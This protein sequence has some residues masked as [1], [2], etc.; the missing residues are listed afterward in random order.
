MKPA[1]Q[2]L[3]FSII[4]LWGCKR[5][6]ITVDD[7]VADCPITWINA[8][9]E[10]PYCGNFPI[11]TISRT[12]KCQS[13]VG[14]L[15]MRGYYRGPNYSY[16]IQG[17]LGEKLS[18]NRYYPLT[19]DFK[20]GLDVKPIE[21]DTGTE[22][23]LFL[24]RMTDTL[25]FGP[26]FGYDNPFEI[27]VGKTTSGYFFKVRCDDFEEIV[28]DGVSDFSTAHLEI[29]RI[30]SALTFR[31][32]AALPN[33]KVIS[34]NHEKTIDFSS[35]AFTVAIGCRTVPEYIFDCKTRYC[36]WGLLDFQYSGQA[37]IIPDAFDCNSVLFQ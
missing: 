10:P 19:T 29:Q 32:N 11:D 4:T 1:I 18:F 8:Y 23:N 20:V 36:S 15:T 6:N 28:S 7:H 24:G 34:Y 14:I 22:M 17:L 33:S 26:S 16:I 2:I 21:V 3:L 9:K 37:P 13:K 31:I 27:I 5:E 25:I 12:V 35:R 30:G